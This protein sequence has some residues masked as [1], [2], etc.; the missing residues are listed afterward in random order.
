[1]LSR[2]KG[3]ATRMNKVEMLKEILAA[4]PADAFARYGLAM[5]YA[6]QGEIETA[7]SQ[8]EQLLRDHP[9]YIAGYFMMAQTLVKAARIDQAKQRLEAG[10][11]CARRA[12]NGHALSEMQGLLDDLQQGA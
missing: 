10:I 9:G 8:F 11:D 4:N 12:G 1:M 6:R 3:N 7:L 2:M 5:E